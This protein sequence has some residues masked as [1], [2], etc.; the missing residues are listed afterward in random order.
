MRRIVKTFATIAGSIAAGVLLVAAW[1]RDGEVQEWEPW[2]AW[3]PASYS[4]H[5]QETADVLWE[6]VTGRLARQGSNLRPPG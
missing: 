4:T 1:E 5:V 6:L 2:Y 3:E